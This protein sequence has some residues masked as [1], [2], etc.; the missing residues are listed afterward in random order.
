[1]SPQNPAIREAM[2]PAGTLSMGCR[3]RRE[4][5]GVLG[6]VVRAREHSSGFHFLQQAA[7]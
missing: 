7:V 4:A 3:Q 6:K 1:M 5:K 2:P